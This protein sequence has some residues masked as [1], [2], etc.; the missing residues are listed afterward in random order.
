[1][2]HN[3]QWPEFSAKLSSDKFA[4]QRVP[5]TELPHMT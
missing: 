5:G 2:L 1:M 3:Y 4:E